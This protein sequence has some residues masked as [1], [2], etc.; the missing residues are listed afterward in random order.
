MSGPYTPASRLLE[1]I[2]D[3][4]KSIKTLA[5]D[6][7]G[8][9]KVS[10]ST[11]AQ[12][13]HVLE[14]Q[15]VLA[16]L[17]EAIPVPCRNEALLYVL[18]YEL[19]LGPNHK[20][21][22]GGALKRAIM[23]KE[24]KFRDVLESLKGT[25]TTVTERVSFPR[26]VRVNTL[27][28]TVKEA[29]EALTVDFSPIYVDK[30][31][32]DLLVLKPGAQ[33]HNHE[34]VKTG[35]LILQDKSSCFSALCLV[36]GNKSPLRGNCLDA[37][38]AP[39]NKTSHLAASLSSGKVVACDRNEKRLEMLD[40]RMK[41][42]VSNGK[43]KTK[44][45]DFLTTKPADY[46]NIKAILLDPSCSGSGIFTA[47][48]R[49]A[50]DDDEDE[51]GE[52]IEHLSNFQ[53][54]ALKHSMSFT[55]V[56]RIVYSTCSLHKEEN[57]MVAQQ[58]LDSNSEWQLVAPYCLREWKRRGQVVEGI[59]KEQAQCMIRAD[60]G[61]DTNGFFVAYFERTGSVHKPK[62]EDVSAG[63]VVPEGLSIYDGEFVTV[64]TKS[65]TG[66]D[67]ATKGGAAKSKSPKG[68]GGTK[69]TNDKGGAKA[70][71][72][73]GGANKRTES[74][75]DSKEPKTDAEGA[76]KPAKIFAKKKAKKLAWKQR[77][78]EQKKQR[79]LTKEK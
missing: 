7:S 22:G 13:C 28:C 17:L 12:V 72:D 76:D 38:A 29:V 75:E 2:W 16:K 36:E 73:K 45:L 11:Y 14:H 3:T 27:K 19:L 61:D 56:E 24:D 37:C 8:N 20:I 42:L 10:K 78:L 53:L 15:K 57:E 47:L 67:N 18:I 55:S 34:M 41:L 40:R 30:H 32:P 77:Q 51:A 60:R 23:K 64:N 66:K 5:Y 74:T 35:K 65:S 79:L 48:D 63:V 21:R 70:T 31:V 49:L 1:Q 71:K 43:V 54:T 25:Y 52:R 6:H 59:T 46:S 26:Y 68:K 33:I 4:K 44:H 50:D 9:L 62:P 69:A 39:G 58:A